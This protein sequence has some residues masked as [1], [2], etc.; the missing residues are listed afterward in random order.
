MKSIVIIV[1]LS[2][3]FLSITS[4]LVSGEDAMPNSS[5]AFFISD[6]VSAPIVV[7]NLSVGCGGAITIPVNINRTMVPADDMVISK[8]PPIQSVDHVSSGVVCGE[9]RLFSVDT[10]SRNVF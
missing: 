1:Y 3:L 9:V 2:V 10:E 5:G 7:E 6:P 8:E 4:G